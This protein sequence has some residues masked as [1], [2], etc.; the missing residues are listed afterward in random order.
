MMELKEPPR[1]V[2]T[3]HGHVRVLVLPWLQYIALRV[4]RHGIK[5]LSKKTSAGYPRILSLGYYSRIHGEI[6]IAKVGNY[7]LRYLH[8][9]GHANGKGHVMIDCDIMHPYGFMRGTDK[10]MCSDKILPIEHLGECGKN[11][12]KTEWCV[13]CSFL[14]RELY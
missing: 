5:Y 11:I 4:K 13:H 3:L 8:E 6:V 9:E 7:K 10:H 1:H 12:G 14:R 2:N